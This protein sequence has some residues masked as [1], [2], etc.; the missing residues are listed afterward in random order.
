MIANFVP[1]FAGNM[2]FCATVLDCC[3]PIVYRGV[4]LGVTEKE[5]SGRPCSVDGFEVDRLWFEYVHN[6][7]SHVRVVSNVRDVRAG[8]ASEGRDEALII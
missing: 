2:A 4:F 1:V 8:W 3:E 6:S 7:G 5:G